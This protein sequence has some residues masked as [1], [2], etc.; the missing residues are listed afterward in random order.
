VASALGRVGASLPV[1]LLP[2]SDC[3]FPPSPGPD[4]PGSHPSPSVPCADTPSLACS[5]PAA[6]GSWRTTS[7]REVACVSSTCP[8]PRTWWWDGN[9]A[10]A[11]WR[12]EK[13]VTA[14]RWRYGAGCCIG[15]LQRLLHLS[16]AAGQQDVAH[17]ERGLSK[18][19]GF[20][21]HH[22]DSIPRALPHPTFLNPFN[23]GLPCF[24]TLP[25]GAQVFLI[26]CRASVSPSAKGEEQCCDGWRRGWG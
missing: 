21:G 16:S 8:T 13:T 20:A 5:A 3:G 4:H 17:V 2:S 24:L 14:G 10:T 19:K 7:R 18:A 26:H 1:S 25:Q 11:F 22:R 12:K 6:R 9:V 15:F 23:L